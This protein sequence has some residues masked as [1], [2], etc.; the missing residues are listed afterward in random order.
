[1]SAANGAVSVTTK[2]GKPTRWVVTGTTEERGLCWFIAIGRNEIEARGEFFTRLR[3]DHRVD[4]LSV[5]L[6][7]EVGV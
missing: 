2:A 1:M 7:S 5:A 3:A 6:A 4:V